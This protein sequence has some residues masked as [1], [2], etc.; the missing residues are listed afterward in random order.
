MAKN[1]PLAPLTLQSDLSKGYIIDVNDRYSEYLS[2]TGGGWDK[3][4]QENPGF[5]SLT[6]V[7]LPVYDEAT[8]LVFVYKNVVQHYRV[9]EGS[10]IVYRLNS[11]EGELHEVTRRVLSFA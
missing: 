5:H 6:S 3:L 7:S 9:S 4:Y 2:A 1:Q 10:L 8:N 11:V